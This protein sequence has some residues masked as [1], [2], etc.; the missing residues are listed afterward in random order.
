MAGAMFAGSVNPVTVTLTQPVSVGSITL[1]AGQYVM[2][3]YEMSGDEF[4]VV[5]SENVRGEKTSPV[6][7]LATRTE[8][9]ADKTRIVLSKDGDKLHFDKLTVEGVG[10]FEF[11]S[12][13]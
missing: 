9:Q 11:I 3:S 10:A 1:P 8:E 2:T 6:T 13:K 7:L 4:F 12:G 5:R